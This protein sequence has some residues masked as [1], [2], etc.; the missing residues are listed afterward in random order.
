MFGFVYITEN[1]VNGYCYIGQRTVKGTRADETYLGSGTVLMRA[2][3]KYGSHNFRRTIIAVADSK[4]DLDAKEIEMILLHKAVTDAHYYNIASGGHGGNHLAGFDDER[5][6]ALSNKH[7]LRWKNMSPEKRLEFGQRIRDKLCGQIK[8]AEHRAAISAAKIGINNWTP[9]GLKSMV[10][11]RRAQIAMGIGVPPMGNRGNKNYRHS[12]T[13][14]VAIKAG[15]AKARERIF[16]ERDT[17]HTEEGKVA[18]LEKLALHYTPEVRQDHAKLIRE[19][20]ARRLAEY[21][22]KGIKPPKFHW[23]HNPH[24][25]TQRATFSA[26][27]TVPEGWISGMGERKRRIDVVRVGE[28]IAS[29]RRDA[30]IAREVGCAPSVVWQIRHNLNAK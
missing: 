21:K 25:Q 24:D 7:V 26:N 29:G 19:G 4:E 30:D 5:R 2:I 17:Y 12:A 22:A 27:D 28:L 15:V 3:K 16:S 13:N 1:L 23:Y 14:K 8:T 11:T 6:A 20:Q 9:E 18:M 10:E